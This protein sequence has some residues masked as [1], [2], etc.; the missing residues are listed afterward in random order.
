MQQAEAEF[1]PLL[2]RRAARGASGAVV[3]AGVVC[4]LA[5]SSA[6]VSPMAIARGIAVPVVLMALVARALPQHGQAALGW[7]NGIT[8]ARSVLVAGLAAFLGE[9]AAVG[10][11]GWLVAVALVAFGLDGLDGRVARATGTDSPFGARLD[12]ELDSITMVVLAGLVVTVGHA[13]SWVLLVGA[14]RY[15]FVLAGWAWPVLGA[16]L[17]AD[18]RRAWACGVGV[19][20]LVAAMG[21]WPVAGLATGCAVGALVVI[22]GS[23]AIDVGWLLR[24]GWG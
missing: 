4:A 10:H 21:P 20:L 18:P 14:A 22:V 3:A 8:L 17:P 9:P 2:R 7:A 5:V 1:Y 15:L 24:R 11:A 6:G 19:A 16:P 23:F 12:M 13:G